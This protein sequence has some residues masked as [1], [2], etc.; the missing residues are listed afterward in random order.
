[1]IIVSE[2][3]QKKKT[4]TTWYHLYV[5]SKLGHKWAYLQNRNRL[6]DTENRLVVVKGEVGRGGK[7][8]EFG[9]SRG[10]LLYLEWISNK[11]LL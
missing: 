2:V 1:M 4:N 8:W 11:V 6:P 10:K 5:E 3:S 9:I 7:G